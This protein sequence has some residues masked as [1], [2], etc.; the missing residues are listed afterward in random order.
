[1]VEDA[2]S[3][4]S[5]GKAA[6]AIVLALCTSHSREAIVESGVNPDYIV[7]DLS[8]CALTLSFTNYSFSDKS[9]SVSV[10]WLD[11][12]LEVTVDQTADLTA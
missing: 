12:R 1:V 8:R 5:A 7:K 9:N 2:L 10:N 3:G 11:G 6:G 4:I